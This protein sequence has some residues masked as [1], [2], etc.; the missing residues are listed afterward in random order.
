M[1]NLAKL[2]APLG[3]VPLAAMLCAVMLLNAPAQP[4]QKTE[5]PSVPC[6]SAPNWDYR[7]QRAALMRQLLLIQ[8]QIIQLDRAHVGMQHYGNEYERRQTGKSP[9]GNMEGQKHE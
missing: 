8:E 5:Q 1:K 9:N 7:T 2:A 3:L 4:A 6:V